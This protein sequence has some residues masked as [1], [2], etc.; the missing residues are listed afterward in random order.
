M[1]LLLEDTGRISSFSYFLRKW[2][3]S[4][5]IDDT[6]IL[7]C[8]YHAYMHCKENISYSQVNITHGDILINHKLDLG[9]LI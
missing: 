7:A 2:E 6:Y 3:F 4:I 5:E 9:V 1:C 8:S